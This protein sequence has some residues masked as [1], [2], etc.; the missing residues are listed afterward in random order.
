MTTA[1]FGDLIN[2]FLFSLEKAKAAFGIYLVNA[3]SGGNFVYKLN[4]S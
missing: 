4:C 3:T 1:N 2:T